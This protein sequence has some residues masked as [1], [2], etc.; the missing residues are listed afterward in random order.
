[1]NVVTKDCV[2]VLSSQTVVRLE[3]FNV[4]ANLIALLKVEVKMDVA[5]LVFR[6]WQLPLPPPVLAY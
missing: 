1:M 6:Q 4:N 2:A 5:F 3:K